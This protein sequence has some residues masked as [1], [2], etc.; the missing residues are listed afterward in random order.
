MILTKEHSKEDLLSEI[1]K[2]RLEKAN[3][4]K[5]KA[6]LKKEKADLELMIEMSSAHSDNVEEDLLNQIESTIRESEK[7]FR[8]ISETIPIP[9]FVSR[10]SDHTIVFA[11]EPAS[12]LLELPIEDLL[13]NSILDYYKSEY[14][15][16]LMD[17]LETQKSINNYE[18][19]GKKPDGTI[20]W[21]ALYVQTLDF[22]E[23]PCFL[24]ALYD[25]NERKKAE[26]ELKQVKNYLDNI[27]NS[28]PS[29]LIGIDDKERVTHW[30]LEAEKTIGI[31]AEKAKGQPLEIVYP[32]LINQMP[33]VK[34]A[35]QEHKLQKIEKLKTLV[36]EEVIYYDITIY[37]LIYNGLGGAVIRVDN[38]TSRVHF[39][40]IMIQNKRMEEEMKT[41]AAL[42]GALFPDV[43]P[44]I[45]NVNLASFFKSATE[46]GGDWYG[47]M[48]EFENHLFILIGDV[49]GHGTPAAL[50]TATACATCRILEK[51]F[52]HNSKTKPPSPSQIMDYL[53]E[54]VFEAG[55]PNYL[56]TFFI[57]RINLETGQINFC[58]AGHNF[59]LL[60][61]SNGKM[62]HLLNANN[63]LGYHKKTRF[64]ENET[65]LEQGDILF[66]YTDGLIE[67]ESQDGNIWGIHKLLSHLKKYHSFNI[68]KMV[69][70]LVSDMYEFFEGNP[71]N[72][73]VTIVACQINKFSKKEISES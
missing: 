65:Q 49:T 48:T 9:I 42:Q 19:Q 44:D 11:N 3:L 15:Q 52:S 38:V 45:L 6:N 63:P 1:T 55:A 46:S 33:R 4:K 27:I 43:L 59:P 21:A 29:V 31:D 69:D 14:R 39:E 10:I 51:I 16:F 71:F 58:N 67:N 41:A 22:N 56:M 40:E 68:K 61:H 73:D 64:L 13:G 72:D 7:R 50:V 20:F 35:L 36:D 2:L 17:S 8:V 26:E 53:D 34:Q 25:L 24:S 62:K 30:N 70:S 5:E 23:E 37:P 60:I 12:F 18:I 47:F 54:A 28:M 57:A 66:F 32:L